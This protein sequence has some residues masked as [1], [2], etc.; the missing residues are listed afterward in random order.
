MTAVWSAEARGR[1]RT[2]VLGGTFDPFHCGHEAAALNAQRA[3]SLEHIV[4][5]PSRQP[6]HRSTQPLASA[7]DRLAMA[8]IAAGA[9][10]S[11]SVSDTELERTGPSYSF[12]TLAEFGA[13]G[14]APSEVFFITG[15]DAFAEIA[16]WSR[17]PSVLDLANF[18]VIAREGI[19]L[20]SLGNRLPSLAGRMTTPAG[21]T[22]AEGTRIILIDA[23]TPAVSSTEVRRRV[24]HGEPI[25]GMV[26]LAIETYIR[27]HRLYH[28]PQSGV[29]R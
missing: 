28:T 6:P 20:D 1:R 15:S 3:L 25:T 22:G 5:V 11:W 27:D 24:Q 10:K 26:P 4:L 29:G 8:H 23:T 17:Y 12:D 18:V 21:F 9:Q 16:T 13:Q 14:L 7:A 2:G 19:T